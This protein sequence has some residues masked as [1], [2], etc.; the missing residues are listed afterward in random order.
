MNKQPIRIVII[1]PNLADLHWFRLCAKEAGVAVEV[2]HY[3]TGI[4]ALEEWT[5]KSDSTID[6]IVVADVLPM[7]TV[8]E[9]ID[10]ARIIH[11]AVPVAVVGEQTHLPMQV[12]DGVERYSKPL[13]A[14]ECRQLC[15]C[16]SFSRGNSKLF[17]ETEKLFVDL[18]E[19][20]REAALRYPGFDICAPLS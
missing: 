12:V 20:A 6:L 2:I 8:Q 1:E 17:N 14:P 9:L 15:G 7:L 13:S 11:P 3:S 16:H 18:N 4:S 10:A 19:E 5:H